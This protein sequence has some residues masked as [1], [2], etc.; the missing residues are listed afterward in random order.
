[1]PLAEVYGPAVILTDHREVPLSE[2]RMVLYTYSAPDVSPADPC[3]KMRPS[4]K[5]YAV[6]SRCEENSLMDDPALASAIQP[7]N[8]ICDRRIGC[9]ESLDL[10]LAP[11]AA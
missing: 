2:R 5:C 10:Y 8:E 6:A 4:P 3:N 1:M 9:F 11:R 7:A